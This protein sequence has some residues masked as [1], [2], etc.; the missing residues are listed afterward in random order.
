MKN[1]FVIKNNK[2]IHI[3]TACVPLFFFSNNKLINS[4][5]SHANSWHI[6]VIYINL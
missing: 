5:W 1:F 6:V 3:Y 4:D 2:S